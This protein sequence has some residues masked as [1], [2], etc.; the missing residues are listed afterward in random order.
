MNK[1]IKIAIGVV[2]G[3]FVCTLAVI[4]AFVGWTYLV[5]SSTE[6]SKEYFMTASELLAEKGA[7]IGKSVR[8]SGAVIGTTIKFDESNGQ[9]SFFI[10]DIPSDFE[11]VERQGGLAFVLENAVNNP[12]LQKIQIVYVGEKPYLLRNM[13]QAIMTGKLNQDGIFYADE[14]LLKCPTKYKE[15]VPDQVEEN[16]GY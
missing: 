3:L 6:P 16:I 5:V 9:L 11:E 14:L 2:L 8:I 1:I 4:A 15:A 12:N 13:T 10:A 7:A